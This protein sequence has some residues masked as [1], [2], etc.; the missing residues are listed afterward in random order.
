MSVSLWPSF[1][2]TSSQLLRGTRLISF[3]YTEPDSCSK[4]KT[5]HNT[6]VNGLSDFAR[7]ITIT[8]QF[9]VNPT[10]PFRNV[11]EYAI[12]KII[13][14]VFIFVNPAMRGLRPVPRRLTVD[15]VPDK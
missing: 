5:S 1:L 7:S 2:N 15:C 13:L 4:P 12:S 11:F 14:V 8:G 10:R 6:G 3:K 9:P